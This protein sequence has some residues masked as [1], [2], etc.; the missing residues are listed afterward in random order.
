MRKNKPETRHREFGDKV[1]GLW[2]FWAGRGLGG[3]R[4]NRALE[5]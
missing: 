4:S 2:G 5:G 1:L 3:Q